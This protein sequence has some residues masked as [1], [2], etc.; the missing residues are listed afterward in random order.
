MLV[1]ARRALDGL[2]L[3]VAAESLQLHQ[4]LDGLRQQLVSYSQPR[5]T[6]AA[7]DVLPAAKALQATVTGVVPYPGL[8]SFQPED[9][10][11]FRG[12]EQQVA[13]LLSLLAE[14]V[15]GG[16]PLV[17]TRSEEHTSELHHANISYAVFCLKK[18]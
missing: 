18:K 8:A 14:Q 4:R 5:L 1:D 16:P 6:A 3:Q 7:A 10:E 15:L 12:R 11:W 9:A 13:H 17:L 2:R